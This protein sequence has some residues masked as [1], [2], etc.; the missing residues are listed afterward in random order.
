MA[1]ASDQRAELTEAQK[2]ELEQ[3]AKTESINP[4]TGRP[5][6][7]GGGT[8]TKLAK[9]YDLL[10]KQQAA[11]KTNDTMIPDHIVQMYKT[12]PSLAE[13]VYGNYRPESVHDLASEA[14]WQLQFQAFKKQKGPF[15]PGW[16]Y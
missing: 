9:E 4:K 12:N 14:A 7:V 13:M 3:W 16:G 15:P 11:T 10:K 1:S 5:I 8:H 6:R 2:A